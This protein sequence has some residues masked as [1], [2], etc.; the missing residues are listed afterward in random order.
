MNKVYLFLVKNWKTTIIGAATS[1]LTYLTSTG[2]I[3]QPQFEMIIGILVAVGYFL[4]K[5]ADT[6]ISDKTLNAKVDERL[7]ERKQEIS[8][9]STPTH[10]I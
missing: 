10:T 8:D 3:S 4:S 7:E 9:D 5:D 6:T 2:K 1:V